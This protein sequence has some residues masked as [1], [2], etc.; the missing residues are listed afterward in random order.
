[1]SVILHTLRKRRIMEYEAVIRLIRA[2]IGDD[3]DVVV[4]PAFNFLFL[5]GRIEYHVK[6][7]SFE[8]IE[9]KD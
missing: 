3:S 4:V 2:R 8:Y 1:M 9:P 6:N 5:F 7:D